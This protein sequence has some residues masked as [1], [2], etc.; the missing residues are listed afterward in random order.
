M[1][2]HQRTG[3]PI[4]DLIAGDTMKGVLTSLAISA[5]CLVLTSGAQP[6]ELR[7]QDQK[8]QQSRCSEIK[9]HGLSKYKG[10]RWSRVFTD[11]EV[12]PALRALLGRDFGT[13]KESLKEVSFPD[14]A[15]SYLDQNGVLTLEG[16]V[17]GLYTIME[18][19][20][21]IEPCG[22]I[23]AGLLDNGERF[24]FFTNDQ[25]Y[26]SKLPT[27]IEQWR[28]KVE[29]ARSQNGELPKLPVVF[30]TK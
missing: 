14:N 25:Q 30:K 8:A 15:D 10:A 20:L 11:P 19:K 17:A 16:G 18:A 12:G 26:I 2:L 23:Y 24:L 4:G 22:H 1:A 6:S 5:L 7:N 27:A 21:V 13:M 9:F 3:K 28:S 29:A